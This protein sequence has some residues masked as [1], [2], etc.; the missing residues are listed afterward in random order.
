MPELI[1]F[2]TLNLSLKQDEASSKFNENLS[3]LIAMIIPFVPKK[4]K[5]NIR[6]R[7]RNLL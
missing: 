3:F 6:K 2:E 7:Q 1:D 4:K 5:E